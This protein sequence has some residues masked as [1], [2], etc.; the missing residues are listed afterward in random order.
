LTS[1][2]KAIDSLAVMPFVNASA[3]PNTEYLSDGLTES[4][5]YSTSR[6]P[7]LRVTPRSSV[8]RYKG[9]DADDGLRDD[10]RYKSLLK[11]IGL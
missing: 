3:D 4:I 1:K 5:I 8:F 6:L 9:K 11:R 7:N 2:G 10:A